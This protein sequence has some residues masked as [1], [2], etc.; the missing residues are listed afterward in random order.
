MKNATNKNSRI[1]PVNK[2]SSVNFEDIKLEDLI[3]ELHPVLRLSL[4]DLYFT[5][6]AMK[7]NSI[8]RAVELQ[9]S[10]VN[11]K[12]ARS[13]IK[14]AKDIFKDTFGEELYIEKYGKI[15]PTEYGELYISEIELVLKILL[16]SLYKV[17][18]NYG[19]TIKIAASQFMMDLVCQIYPIWQ[20]EL[21]GINIDLQL[22]RTSEMESGLNNRHFDLGFGAT[23]DNGHGEP[24]VNKDLE[25]AGTKIERV[26]ILTNKDNPQFKSEQDFLTL[27]RRGSLILPK[28]GLIKEYTELLEK[29]YPDLMIN[30]INWCHDIFFGI[31]LMQN[32]VIPHG[33]M[34]VLEGAAE[35][36]KSIWTRENQSIGLKSLKYIILP[37]K[38]YS[39]SV[40]VGLFRR[41]IDS[42]LKNNHPLQVCWNTFEEK[43]SLQINKLRYDNSFNKS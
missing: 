37:A 17:K 33:I 28:S 34:F 12:N 14:K 25:F 30:K 23:I 5:L 8:S 1:I 36:T 2:Y 21:K 16:S 6:Y 22:I 39:P 43:F 40:F 19:R 3:K 38:I 11:I 41:K 13:Q 15:I 4:E 27:I 24:V 10:L 42:E 32:N 35:W 26:G 29:K 18:I 7:N 31:S 9:N 20:R